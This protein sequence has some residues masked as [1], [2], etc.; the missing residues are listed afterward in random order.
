MKFEDGRYQV[1]WPWKQESPDLPL[2]RDLAMGRLKSTVSRMKNKPDLM[3]KYDSII[4]DQLDKGVIEKV[5]ESSND[6]QKHYLP[7]H[8][9]VNP[10]KAT[11]KLRVVYDASA[12]TKKENNSL[13]DCLYRGPVLLNDLCGML[14]RF[15]L[16]NIAIVADIEKAF[17][18]IGLQPTQRDVTRF[19]WLKDYET[20]TVNDSTIQEY[21]FCRVPFGVISSPFLLGS[22]TESHLDLYDSELAKKLKHDIYVDNLITGTST[23]EEA[24]QLY[25]AAKS[26][27]KEASMRVR[28]PL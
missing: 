27:F 14:M 10:L 23:I 18:Q 13:N 3:K 16:H 19:L 8:A 5:I 22:T 25:S 6:G 26:I 4:K 2:N 11:T 12:K 24:L 15:R 20:P 28:K 9:V 1:Q 7:H 17:L 21:Q